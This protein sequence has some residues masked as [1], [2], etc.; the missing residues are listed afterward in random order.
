MVYDDNAQA[1]QTECSILDIISLRHC[2]VGASTFFNNNQTFAILFPKKMV[3]SNIC[4][5][6]KSK[7]IFEY[8]Q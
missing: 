5:R 8:N 4:E 1:K 6:L 7:P 3:C 2:M